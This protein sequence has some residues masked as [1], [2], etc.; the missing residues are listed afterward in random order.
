MTLI[1]ILV[2]LVLAGAYHVLATLFQGWAARRTSAAAGPAI[3]VLG[4][5]VRLT[6]IAVILIVIG[7]WAPLNI[8][9]LALAFVV[10]FTI[11]NGWSIYRLMS[12]RHSAP[13][14]AG[15]GGLT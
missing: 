3:V 5:M 6:V 11:L 4:F 1:S 13:P 7:V 8:L 10:L 14:S 2:G 9:P 12:K 15:A